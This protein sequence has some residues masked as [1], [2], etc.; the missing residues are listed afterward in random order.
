[1]NS[2]L[3]DA[4]AL[5]LTIESHSGP[6]HAHRRKAPHRLPRDVWSAVRVSPVPSW[7]DYLTGYHNEP[8]D[9]DRLAGRLEMDGSSH[10]ADPHVRARSILDRRKLS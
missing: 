10:G 1:M 9:Q 3:L 6:T 8:Y 5:H 2:R 4:G 7:P